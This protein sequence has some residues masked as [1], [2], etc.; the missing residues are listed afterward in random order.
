MEYIYEAITAKVD[1]PDSNIIWQNYTLQN[2][3]II[4]G[5][6]LYPKMLSAL[7]DKLNPAEYKIS[8]VTT[9][10]PIPINN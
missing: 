1:K 10:L 9:Q 6:T 8:I 2:A 3:D 4:M 5:S 7:L